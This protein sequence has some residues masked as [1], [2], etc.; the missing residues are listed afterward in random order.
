MGSVER[1]DAQ[2]SGWFKITPTQILSQIN[3]PRGENA[4]CTGNFLQT[5]WRVELNTERFGNFAYILTPHLNFHIGG[6]S[7]VTVRKGYPKPDRAMILAFNVLNFDLTWYIPNK[8]CRAH[9][10]GEAGEIYEY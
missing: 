3:S 8:G 5:R 1:I 7:A 4:K 10:P 6:R 2:D 9:S